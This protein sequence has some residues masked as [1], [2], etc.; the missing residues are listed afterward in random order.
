MHA[1]LLAYKY[2]VPD[3][4]PTAFYDL[5]L[6]CEQSHAGRDYDL[7]PLDANPQLLR[8]YIKGRGL[9]RTAIELDPRK[10]LT[11]TKLQDLN[12]ECE[13][14]SSDECHTIMHTWYFQRYQNYTD[15][16]DFYLYGLGKLIEQLRNCGAEGSC[17]SCQ[18]GLADWLVDERQ[19]FW[20]KLPVIFQVVS[21]IYL[22]NRGSCDANVYDAEGSRP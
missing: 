20:T 17:S 2:N 4:L 9:I 10:F 7:S 3:I 5:Y 12:D 15:N 14:P 1:L 13:L 8:Y 22:S 19:K 18:D 16:A 11:F 21:F 6:S